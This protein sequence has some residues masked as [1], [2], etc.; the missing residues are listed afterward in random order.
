VGRVLL[1]GPFLG[2]LGAPLVGAAL[3]TA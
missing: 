1:A 2:L 3:G